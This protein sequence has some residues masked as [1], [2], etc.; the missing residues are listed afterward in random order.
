MMAQVCYFSETSSTPRLFRATSGSLDAEVEGKF[1]SGVRIGRMLSCLMPELFICL[2]AITGEMIVCVRN[3]EAFSVECRELVRLEL[4]RPNRVP[5]ILN[6]R[7]MERLNSIW[8][9]N[10][11]TDEG[12]ALI[13]MDQL[14]ENIHAITSSRWIITDNNGKRFDL[15]ELEQ[16]DYH[17]LQCWQD[18]QSLVSA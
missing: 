9:W 11:V 1:Y 13:V 6:L 3:L 14:G 18:I 10:V 4:D 8:I 17:S 16:M 15:T 5:R 2:Y 12:D 7:S